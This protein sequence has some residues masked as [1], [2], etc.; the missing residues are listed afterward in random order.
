MTTSTVTD[1][2]VEI[3]VVGNSVLDNIKHLCDQHI[4]TVS[5]G[6]TVLCENELVAEQG[7]FAA[8]LVLQGPDG[9][10]QRLELILHCLREIHPAE[11]VS[12]LVVEVVARNNLVDCSV[13]PINN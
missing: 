3:S 7:P 9:V 2:G 13:L 6:A 12:Q 4:L 8:S 11:T 1:H 5:F 10:G